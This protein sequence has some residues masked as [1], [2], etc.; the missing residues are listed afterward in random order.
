MALCVTIVFLNGKYSNA[1]YTSK[2]W[3]ELKKQMFNR[4]PG[5]LDKT[6]KLQIKWKKTAVASLMMSLPV[7][8]LFFQYSGSSNPLT[9]TQM[10]N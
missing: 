4:N 3:L 1:T 9:D 2:T 6:E 8:G 7:G 10:T 5:T